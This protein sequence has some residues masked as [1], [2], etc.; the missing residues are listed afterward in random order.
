[1]ATQAQQQTAGKNNGKQQ[2]SKLTLVKSQQ[3]QRKR[4]RPVGS[5]SN[6]LTASLSFKF[7]NKIL[8]PICKLQ[9]EVLDLYNKISPDSELSATMIYY[10]QS[11]KSIIGAAKEIKVE[12]QI[13]QSK[14][15]LGV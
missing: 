5:K 15:Q 4:G 14:N 8:T 1:M 12:L 2:E 13:Q 10:M 3:Q 9:K 7:E 6:K 11:I